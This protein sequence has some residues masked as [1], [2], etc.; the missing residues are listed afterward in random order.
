MNYVCL[1]GKVMPG[2]EPVLMADNRGYRYGDGL[3]ETMKMIKG[4]IL[5][6]KFHFDRLFSGLDLMKFVLPRLFTK[7]NLLEAILQLS[8][9]NNCEELGRT[10]LS[11][12]RGNGGL[13][14]DNRDAQYLV[15]SWGL[16]E[17]ENR[18]N[19]SGLIIDIFNDAK[20]SCDQFSNLKSANY[21]PYTMAAIHAQENKYNDCLVLNTQGRICDSSIANVFLIRNESIITPPLSEGCVDGVMR[22]WLVET[23]GNRQYATSQPASK[24]G[25]SQEI[26]FR[27]QEAPVTIEDLE[28]ASEIF[29]S[30]A[31][32]GIRWVKQFRKVTYSNSDTTNI[33]DQFIKNL[34][35]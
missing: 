20:K 16:D 14:N 3:F 34:W 25:G 12:F 26:N 23:I 2:N 24:D 15:E 1:N 7:E 9:K 33:Y 35:S 22:K 8:K 21:L 11:V 18:L 32:Y 29:L 10:R 5:L 4:K 17:Q 6:E 31:I 30:N 13:H 28:S 19:E 27:I